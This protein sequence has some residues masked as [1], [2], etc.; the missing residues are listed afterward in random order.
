MGEDHV[1][2]FQLETLGIWPDTGKAAKSIG[3]EFRWTLKPIALDDSNS[4]KV[5][6]NYILQITSDLASLLFVSHKPWP[7]TTLDPP[8]I[9]SL[10]LS[11]F[12]SRGCGCAPQLRARALAVFNPSRLPTTKCPT[13][14]PRKWWLDFTWPVFTCSVPWPVAVPPRPKFMLKTNVR[15]FI[16]RRASVFLVDILQKFCG[17]DSGTVWTTRRMTA[18]S[19]LQQVDGVWSQGNAQSG[20]GSLCQAP[21]PPCRASWTGMRRGSWTIF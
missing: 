2:G 18:T 13:K 7:L 20:G 1:R 5:V 11:S 19:P 15:Y 17:G 6:L 14:C 10:T 21:A 16:A 8:L 12:H 4:H 9:H 3:R